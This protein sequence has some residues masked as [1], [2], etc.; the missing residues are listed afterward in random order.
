MICLDCLIWERRQ[1]QP[2]RS[3]GVEGGSG[4]WE[5]LRLNWLISVE[6]ACCFSQL[7]FISAFASNTSLFFCTS[8]LPPSQSMERRV[9]NHAALSS[10][11]VKWPKL[12]QS[13]GAQ[14][15]LPRS[16]LRECLSHFRLRSPEP[17][18]WVTY[19]PQIFILHRSGGQETREPAWSS[20]GGHSLLGFGLLTSSRVLMWPRAA[21]K[22][23]LSWLL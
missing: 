13:G 16:W 15:S 21:W 7:A 11:G 5:F 22:Q 17:A 12:G 9:N 18:D 14:P 23:A 2:I 19:K 4:S 10:K 1:T 8:K 3:R 20:S 6:D